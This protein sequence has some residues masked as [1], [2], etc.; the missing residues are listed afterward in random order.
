MVRTGLTVT[1]PFTLQGEGLPGTVPLRLMTPALYEATID[2]L[3]FPPVNVLA[4]TF[5]VTLL[6]PGPACRVQSPVGLTKVPQRR[7]LGGL[8]LTL[9][10]VALPSE[11]IV[12]LTVTVQS[13]TIVCESCTMPVAVKDPAG[14]KVL[15]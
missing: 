4:P 5:I 8:K 1:D 7:L 14:L 13:I 12:P 11:F 3:Q 2:P 10:T 6:V 9:V 15:D